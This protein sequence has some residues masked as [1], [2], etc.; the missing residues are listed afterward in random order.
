MAQDYRIRFIYDSSP[1]KFEKA[2]KKGNSEENQEE[3]RS[4]GEGEK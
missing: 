4:E 3:R 2:Q 1:P